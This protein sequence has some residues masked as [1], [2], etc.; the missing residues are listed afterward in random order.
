MDAK[1]ANVMKK[2]MK[3]AASCSSPL[4]FLPESDFGA[5][6]PSIKDIRAK[7]NIKLAHTMAQ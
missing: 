4:L 3:M 7:A 1:I 6:L 5:E 2:R